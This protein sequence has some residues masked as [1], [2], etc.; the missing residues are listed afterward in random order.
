MSPDQVNALF[1][2]GAGLIMLPTIMRAFRLKEVKGIH[3]L[4]PTF[5]LF[6]AMWSAWYFLGLGQYY[7]VAS[8]A[9]VLLIDITWLTMVLVYTKTT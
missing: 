6:W 9:I 3:P 2:A 8:C 1:T 4:T 7:S 5:Y